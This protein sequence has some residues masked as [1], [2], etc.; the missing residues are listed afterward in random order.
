M[1]LKTARCVCS[2]SSPL[3]RQEK[4]PKDSVPE[5]HTREAEMGRVRNSDSRE[6]EKKV[7]KDWP[8][9]GAKSPPCSTL[10]GTLSQ[11]RKE[12]HPAMDW[13]PCPLGRITAHCPR[14]KVSSLDHL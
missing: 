5:R 3:T 8:W 14:K 9:A 4:R 6:K 11:E 7:F 13:L 10:L 12:V 1:Y 2:L